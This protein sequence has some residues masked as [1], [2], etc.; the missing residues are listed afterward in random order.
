MLVILGSVECRLTDHA[1]KFLEV[2]LSPNVLEPD[3]ILS[4]RSYYSVY[5]LGAAK[6]EDFKKSFQKYFFKEKMQR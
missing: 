3:S 4:T 5:A 2:K 1:R 6:V